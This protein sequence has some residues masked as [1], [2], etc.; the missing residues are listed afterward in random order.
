MHIYAIMTADE[1]NISYLI[2]IVYIASYRY[3]HSIAR[4][5]ANINGNQHQSREYYV[6]KA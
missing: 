5:G 2:Y 6:L 4:A 3:Y 1:D